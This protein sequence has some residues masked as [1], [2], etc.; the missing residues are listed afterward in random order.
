MCHAVRVELTPQE[1]ADARRLTV[2]LVPIYAAAVLAIIALAAFNAAPRTGS[3]VA[4]MAHPA[5]ALK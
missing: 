2:R 4:T 5:A 1:R 3:M